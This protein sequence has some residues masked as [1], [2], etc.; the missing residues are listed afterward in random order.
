M[1]IVIR[2]IV[3][4][5]TES[6]CLR[7]TGGSVARNVQT[8]APVSFP[9]QV[10]LGAVLRSTMRISRLENMY[11]VPALT[12]ATLICSLFVQGSSTRQSELGSEIICWTILPFLFRLGERLNPGIA[13][14][15]GYPDI[16]SAPLKTSWVIAASLTISSVYKAEIGVVGLTVSTT[17]GA[18]RHARRIDVP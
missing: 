6:V 16:Q 15:F 7:R 18:R 10:H 8:Q 17:T 13:E 4:R 12:G 5:T 14:L 2:R 11:T 9:I 1:P 3:C